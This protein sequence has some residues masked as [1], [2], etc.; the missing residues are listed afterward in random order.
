MEKD[1]IIKGP[2][3]DG[4]RTI[5]ML[6]GTGYTYLNKDGHLMPHRFA[7]AYDFQN[8]MAIVELKD[9]HP[10]R[11][12]TY[13]TA[14][15]KVLPLRFEGAFPF[16]GDTATAYIGREE[17]F[18]DK[19]GLCFQFKNTIVDK[20]RPV[21]ADDMKGGFKSIMIFNPR[22]G[23]TYTTIFKLLGRPS[24][25]M[26]PIEMED[27]SG[28][29]FMDKKFNIMPHRF[30][31]V[32]AFKGGLAPVVTF[33]KRVVYID[34]QGEVY[35]EKQVENMLNKFCDDMKNQR[36]GF[37]NYHEEEFADDEEERGIAYYD[38]DYDEDDLM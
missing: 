11:R 36:N 14:D 8:Q 9:G 26:F 34:K 18:V 12:A 33:G 5:K 28:Q 31:E 24:E 17:Y 10:E 22:T 35:T 6:D 27:G 7:K 37:E 32:G 13:V 20:L 3:A 30:L 38:E 2:E 21:T 23:K 15:E 4:W 16:Y 29:T 25:G 19:E 1:Y